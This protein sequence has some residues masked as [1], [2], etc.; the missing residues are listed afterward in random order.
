MHKCTDADTSK[1]KKL[2]WWNKYS[3]K[4]FLRAYLIMIAQESAKWNQNT[5]NFPSKHFWHLKIFSGSSISV[6]RIFS[7]E[8]QDLHKKM[9]KNGLVQIA[10][11]EYQTAVEC[12]IKLYHYPGAQEGFKIEKGIIC[13][14][15]RKSRY[16][17]IG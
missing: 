4:T 10:A 17:V 1:L 3:L 5:I 14:P 11:G 16:I 13:P 9:L 7:F 12:R 6:K 8:V 2:Y 15:D